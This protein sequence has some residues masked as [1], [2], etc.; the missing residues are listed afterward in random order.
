MVFQSTMYLPSPGLSIVV[1][2]NPKA[3][4]WGH[5]VPLPP[6]KQGFQQSLAIEAT[7]NHYHCQTNII[8]PK[9]HQFVPA[10]KVTATHDAMFISLSVHCPQ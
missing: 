1:A 8:T 7:D 3:S 4:G 9:T 5:Y 6:C 10:I 2:R